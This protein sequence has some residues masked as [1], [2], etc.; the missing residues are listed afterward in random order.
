MRRLVT[1]ALVGFLAACGAGGEAG[2]AGAAGASGSSSNQSAVLTGTVNPAAVFNSPRDCYFFPNNLVNGIW[3]RWSDRILAGSFG[4][5]GYW[6][7][8]ANTTSYPATPTVD[9]GV[10]YARLVLVPDTFTVVHAGNDQNPSPASSVFVG[11]IDP[12]GNMSSFQP[13][14]FGDGY[15]GNCNLISAS[16]KEFLCYDGAAVRHYATTELSPAL[17]L[18]KTVTLSQQPANNCASY[19]FGGT[20]AWD[21]AYYYFSDQ[22]GVS[23]SLVYDAYGAG[24]ARAGQY[25][26]SGTGNITGVYFEWSVGAYATH[27]GYGARTGTNNYVWTGGTAS[28]DSQCYTLSPAHTLP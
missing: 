24:G 3:H 1:V 2:P 15:T 25:T 26:A 12:S 7:F 11:H 19:C 21:G 6:S 10:K 20:F 16:Q 13:A 23:G 18:V 22:G 8:P 28:D 9:T 5:N 27:D 17:R 14:V 4:S